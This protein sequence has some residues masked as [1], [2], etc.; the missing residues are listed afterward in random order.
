LTAGGA[1][2]ALI[3]AKAKAKVRTATTSEPVTFSFISFLLL[4]GD[5]A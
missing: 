2:K 1:A 3:E 5:L 4:V